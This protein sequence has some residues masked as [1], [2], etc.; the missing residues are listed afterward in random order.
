[1][2]RSLSDFFGIEAVLFYPS[3]TMTNEIAIH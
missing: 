2:E 1:L 3:G